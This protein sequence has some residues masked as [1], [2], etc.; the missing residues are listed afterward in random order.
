MDFRNI[1][2][3]Y[4]SCDNFY[5]FAKKKDKCFYKRIFDDCMS[6]G[7]QKKLSNY[8][9]DLGIIDVPYGSRITK[10]DWDKN[11]HTDWFVDI[12]NM[13]SIHIK[14][15]GS[16][17]FFGGIGKYKDRPFYELG[18]KLEEKT[19]WRIYDHITWGK[20]R[21]IGSPY[22]YGFA[23]EEIFF[24]VNDNERPKTFNIPLLDKLRGYEGFN[25]KYPAKSP[26]LRR[27]NVWSD[28][29][30]IINPKER[31][32]VCQKPFPLLK[33]IIEASS[34]PGDIVLDTFAGSFSTENAC[35]KLGRSC[36]SVEKE[37]DSIKNK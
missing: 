3:I 9:F 17:Y 26:Y 37:K 13:L 19:P 30:E 2:D 15:G 31:V 16:C 35:R 23:R 27:T 18:S 5:K 20:K 7:T 33:I 11:V 12:L 24:L 28:I 1:Y 10:K 4:Y 36:V 25:K 14:K 8:K 21:F 22:K 34:N 6:P 32:H 29:S